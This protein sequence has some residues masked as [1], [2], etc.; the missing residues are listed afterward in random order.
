MTCCVHCA[1]V[2]VWCLATQIFAVGMRLVCVLRVLDVL[3]FGDAGSGLIRDTC[4]CRLPIFNLSPYDAA[5]ALGA[6]DVLDW[7]WR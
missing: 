4:T 1:A 3:A 6:G 2:G 5:R 7:R